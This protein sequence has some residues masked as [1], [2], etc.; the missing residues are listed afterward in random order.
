M[1][2]LG[3]A[4]RLKQADAATEALTSTTTACGIAPYL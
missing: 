2:T 3:Y 1:K 4:D